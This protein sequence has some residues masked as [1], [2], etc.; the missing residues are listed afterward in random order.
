M[1]PSFLREKSISFDS[2]VKVVPYFIRWI[3]FGLDV[4][5]PV[6]VGSNIR[7]T[8]RTMQKLSCEHNVERPTRMPCHEL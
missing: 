6:V 1:D 4:T 8:K 5:E 7:V 2:S 3:T